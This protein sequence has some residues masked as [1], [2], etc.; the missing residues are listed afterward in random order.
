MEEKPKGGPRL[1][2]PQN[3]ESIPHPSALKAKW[4]RLGILLSVMGVLGVVASIRWIRIAEEYA[5]FRPRMRPRHNRPI[6]ERDGRTLLWAL[7]DPDSDE[8]QWFD[9]TD[10][11]IDPATFQFGLGK[12]AI[13]AI[14]EPVFV[15]VDD[16]R[17][18]KARIGDN[19][20]VIGYAA[21]G[22]AKAYPLFIMSRHELV[23][24]RFAGTPVTVGW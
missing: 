3:Q 18:A 21:S 23:N 9:M 6:L 10:S 17:L 16:P 15:E 22:E 20:V 2:G 5:V 7:G 14:D 12:D 8:A 11:L 4:L 13:R 1:H 19:T 24:D